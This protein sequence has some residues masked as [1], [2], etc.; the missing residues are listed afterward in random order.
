L[1]DTYLFCF[2]LML[3]K[4]KADKAGDSR[5]ASMTDATP[6]STE[7]TDK[8]TKPDLK[9]L[10]NLVLIM[11][12]VL[13]R[14]AEL[15]L[16]RKDKE[17]TVN[18]MRKLVN[19]TKQ[20]QRR[21]KVGDA[22]PG[23]G[24]SVSQ[25]TCAGSPTEIDLKLMFEGFFEEHWLM[26]STILSVAQLQFLTPDDIFFSVTD[27]NEEVSPEVTLEKLS[28]LAVCFYAISTEYR[29]K[30]KIDE[31]KEKADKKALVQKE[32]TIIAPRFQAFDINKKLA[33][34]ELAKKAKDQSKRTLEVKRT[35]PPS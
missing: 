33:D 10:D 14:V 32:T 16:D 20:R 2:H 17:Q 30:E 22:V 4:D 27:I 3:K 28:L 26:T 5:Q 7:D 12:R 29:F 23:D 19:Q 18:L 34:A 1:Y 24:P 21:S 8:A 15:G 11:E 9:Y 6:V 35:V 25:I 31:I 13:A